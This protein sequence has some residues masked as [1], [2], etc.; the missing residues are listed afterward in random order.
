MFNILKFSYK[1]IIQLLNTVL[2]NTTRL[3]AKNPI[4]MM[5]SSLIL[6]SV[7]YVYLFNLAKASEL[8]AAA[9][10]PPASEL[11][12]I[13]CDSFNDISFS[14][15]LIENISLRPLPKSNTLQLLDTSK[16]MNR[17]TKEKSL[18]NP[19]Q[20]DKD[21]H[22]SDSRL[23]NAWTYRNN[24]CNCDIKQLQ[25][26]HDPLFKSKLPFNSLA[27]SF[28]FDINTS[29]HDQATKL[30]EQKVLSLS[31]DKSVPITPHHPYESASTLLW[32][33]RIIKIISKDINERINVS[34]RVR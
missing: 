15:P 33:A 7:T 9:S 20:L 11:T 26:D 29:Q 21:L 34:T 16:E 1:S 28:P 17:Y 13:L 10:Y 2:I 6:G 14:S 18:I 5:I 22:L 23:E 27:L 19:S 32:L 25:I 31:L 30:W 12:S 3:S 8:L 24:L 4:K